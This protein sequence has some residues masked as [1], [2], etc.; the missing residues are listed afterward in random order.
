MATPYAANAEGIESQ[1]ATNHLGHF[2]FTALVFP[3]VLAAAT[4]SAPARIVLVSSRGHRRSDIRWDDLHFSG[5]KTYDPWLA[6]GQSKT[7][8]ILFAN[9]IAR[10]SS[11]KGNNVLAY[12]LH[13]GGA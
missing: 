13:P 5:G 9:E 10:R 8:N 12:S 7:A 1:F 3:R 2:L 6:Y 11:E 4:P